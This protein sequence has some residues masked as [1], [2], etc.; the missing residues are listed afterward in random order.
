MSCHCRAALTPDIDVIIMYVLFMWLCF[1]FCDNSKKSI[2]KY[3]SQMDERHDKVD[4]VVEYN[5]L[6]YKYEWKNF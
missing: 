4:F 6:V 3:F 2:D 1:S 5:I